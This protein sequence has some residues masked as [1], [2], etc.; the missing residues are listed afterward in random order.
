MLKWIAVILMTI[1]HIGYYFHPYL[2]V[3]VY[4]V[5]RII[6]RLAFPIF[7]F[8]L[9]KG[10]SR[11]S[12]HLRHL[13]RMLSWA[14]ITHFIIWISETV[15]GSQ[16]SILDFSWTNVLV[17]FS[18]GIIMLMGYEL[19]MS[20]YKDMI[21]SMSLISDPPMQIKNTRYDVKVNLGGI[22]MSPKI[23]IPLGIVLI[24][25]SFFA[26][27]LFNAD[28]NIYGLATILLIH[29]F[30]NKEEGKVDL[31]SL[32]ISLTALNLF[33]LII[34]V[35]S[36]ENIKFSLI[37]CFSIAAIFFF[38]QTPSEKKKPTIWT[39][40]F[41]YIFYPAHISFFIIISFYWEKIISF[42]SS[43]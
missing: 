2:P 4:F 20:C 34:A 8:Y 26:V 33:Y 3:P 25:F 15:A 12:N 14:L 28:Y 1:D 40:Y 11:T 41:F 35:V 39:K 16:I 43:L 36:K 6:G 21:A 18:F 5:M 30:Y 22:T 9:V 7:S 37:Q 42:V 13:L 23:G 32:A 27:N 17:L 31:P 10:F 29:I 38:N 19:A 24:L